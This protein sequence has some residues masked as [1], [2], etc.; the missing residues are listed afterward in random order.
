[1]TR[2]TTTLAR[3][4]VAAVALAI[5]VPAVAAAQSSAQPSIDSAPHAVSFRRDARITGH[6]DNGSPGTEVKL[7]RRN[8]GADWRS[9]G[10]D[11]TDDNG[12]VSFVAETLRVSADYRL[13]SVDE[14]GMRTRSDAIEIL[15]RPRLRF[16]ARP[17]NVMEGRKVRIAGSLYPMVSGRSVMV[18]KKIAGEW[19]RVDRLPVQDGSFAAR[20]PANRVGRRHL[21]VVFRGDD[22]NPRRER[23]G[24]VTIY[25]KDLA[26]WYGPG[27]Y[28]HRTA[29]G[30][31][32]SDDTLGVAHRS[33]PC[34]TEVSILYEGRTITVPVID[35]GPYSSAD[36]DLTQETAERLG[37]EGTDTIGVE[38]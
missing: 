28:G 2:P 35:R 10:T 3:A 13:V 33:L 27:F 38:H 16:R 9:I 37:F 29:C 31:R 5:M 7:Q 21:R 4:A 20:F 32:L 15:I 18:Q 25:E 1:M 11:T 30:K 26:T 8:P 14:A 19:Q 23:T 12:A 24:T 36:W 34:G 6:L 22:L 17:R